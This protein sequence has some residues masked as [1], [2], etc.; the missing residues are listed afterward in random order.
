MTARY[1]VRSGSKDDYGLFPRLARLSEIL[2]FETEKQ[3]KFP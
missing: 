1:G 2:R 3:R